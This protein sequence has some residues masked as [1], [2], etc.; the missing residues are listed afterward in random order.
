VLGNN[1]KDLITISSLNFLNGLSSKS[2]IIDPWRIY[3]DFKKTS[4]QIYQLGR[5]LFNNDHQ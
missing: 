4:A 1:S 3:Q 5:G 2:L